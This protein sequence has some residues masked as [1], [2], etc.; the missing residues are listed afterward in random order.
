MII[1]IKITLTI[2]III[3]IRTVVIITQHSLSDYTLTVWCAGQ[4]IWWALWSIYGDTCK[5]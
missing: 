3:I 1:I 5:S 4:S 2:T